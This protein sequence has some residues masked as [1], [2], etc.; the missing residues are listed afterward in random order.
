MKKKNFR[1]D[2]KSGASIILGVLVCFFMVTVFAFSNKLKTSYALPTN[3]DAK[4]ISEVKT[5]LTPIN[6]AAGSKFADSVVMVNKFTSEFS[7]DNVNYVVDMFCLEHEKGMPDATKYVK[8]TNSDSYVDAGIANIVN[9]AYASAKETVSGSNTVITL[10]NDE[11]Y[12]AQSAIWIYQEILN[13]K[14]ADIAKMW[15]SVQALKDTNA[16]AKAIYD[17]VDSAKNVKSS[18]LTNSIKLSDGNP[19]LKL[20]ADKNYY[21]TGVMSVAVTTAVNTEFS[22]FKFTINSNNYTTTVVDESNNEITDLATIATGKKFKIRVAATN[23][24]A[25][26]EAT[27]TGDISGVFITHT[28]LAYQDQD[29]PTESQIA[30]LVT[31]NYKETTV[32]LKLNIKVPDTGSNYSKYIYIVGTLV[33]V[34]GLSVIYVNTK[35]RKEQ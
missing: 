8:V 27:I 33:L 25:G 10:S 11:Y 15:T 21:E 7:K 26:N 4:D 17:Y 18:N 16:T 12:I 5:K 28:F 6:I 9:R 20:S 29:N 19:E 3:L 32:P 22:G 2:G 31:N 24:N 35:T 13:A 30:L 34:I 23:L 1:L 14:N